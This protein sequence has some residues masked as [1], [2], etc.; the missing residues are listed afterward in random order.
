MNKKIASVAYVCQEVTK[1]EGKWYKGIYLAMGFM[2]RHPKHC[3]YWTKSA[4]PGLDFE[5]LDDSLC[6]YVHS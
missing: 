6:K 3:V 5:D 4:L 2:Y 1:V